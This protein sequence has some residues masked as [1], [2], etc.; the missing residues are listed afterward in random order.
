MLNFLDEID[1]HISYAL[2]T[3]RSS[4]NKQ[5][6]LIEIFSGLDT[7]VIEISERRP[8]NLHFHLPKFF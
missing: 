2:Y 5:D 1:E 8:F 3:L 4:N 6:E 7:V